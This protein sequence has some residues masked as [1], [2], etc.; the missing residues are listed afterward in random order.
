MVGVVCGVSGF[1]S[2]IMG[3]RGLA[4]VGGEPDT[5]EILAVS[6]SGPLPRA[7]LLLF[8]IVFAFGAVGMA[9]D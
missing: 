5:H 4:V 8:W 7:L 6:N 3:V 9:G 2:K 1:L